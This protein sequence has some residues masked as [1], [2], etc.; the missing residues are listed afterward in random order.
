[1]SGEI[2]V[3]RGR[4][5]TEGERL[6]YAKLNQAGAPIA[7]I[8]A[9][10][11]TTTEVLLDGS[12]NDPTAALA[13]AVAATN[14]F[15]NPAL[16]WN[17]WISPSGLLCR[18]GVKTENALG[19]I[20]NPSGTVT[21]ENDGLG[22]TSQR[23][24]K[25]PTAAEGGRV[26][27]SLE[28]RGYTGITTVDVGQQVPGHLVTT[29]NHR[30]TCWVYNATGSAF[31]LAARIY[32]PN[33]TDDFANLANTENGVVDVACPNLEWTKVTASLLGE[34]PGAEIVFRV[35]S[36][37]LDSDEKVIRF[38]QWQLQPG[39]SPG[40]WVP[41]QPEAY[42]NVFGATRAP[43]VND[44]CASGFGV[45]SQWFTGTEVYQCLNAA[46]G[47]ALWSQMTLE[48]RHLVT[49]ANK[50]ASGTAGGTATSGSWQTEPFNT[51]VEDTGNLSA[52]TAANPVA[53]DNLGAFALPAGL[54]QFDIEVP[55]Y[56]VN[57]FQS[58]LY[59]VD[60][61][62]EAVYLDTE[63]AIYGTSGYASATNT[64]HAVSVM[65]GRLRL[66]AASTKLRVETKVAATKATD[67]MGYAGSM[68]DEY[69]ATAR[70]TLISA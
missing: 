21:G 62:A 8:D 15:R 40:L 2:T 57:G 12:A 45:G 6:D 51:I 33:S 20:V 5:F 13:D 23:S 11:I 43:T 63:T 49:L 65:R 56:A 30:M 46:E 64:G 70:F 14:L 48:V 69:Y 68:G 37:S 53:L 32:Y 36:G 17:K 41:P 54:W 67:G 10:A 7:R 26:G 3:T 16:D 42:R 25:V 39:I 1:M 27:A 55:R 19:W 61:G 31:T 59:N 50:Q 60:G 18:S 29:G 22:L 28:L 34:Y 44:D 35:P 52:S 4:T 9:N 24:S 58:R 66:T 47:A 38:A